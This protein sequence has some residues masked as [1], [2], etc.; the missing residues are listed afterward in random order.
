MS[1]LDDKQTRLLMVERYLN[2][3]TSTLEERQLADYFSTATEPLTEE[4][5]S[6]WLILQATTNAGSTPFELSQSKVAEF[7]RLMRK[8]VPARHRRLAIAGWISAVAAAASIA[9]L[10]VLFAN[11]SGNNREQ[12]GEQMATTQPEGIVDRVENECPRTPSP[13]TATNPYPTDNIAENRAERQQASALA[14]TQRPKR[15]KEK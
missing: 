4:E 13:V 5:E 8:D 3:E 1:K 14:G 7:D 12:P 9:I 15:A 11:R 6:A 10:V 2:A